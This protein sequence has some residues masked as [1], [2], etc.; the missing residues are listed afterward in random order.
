MQLQ[1]QYKEVKLC[2]DAGISFNH[3]CSVVE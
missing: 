1:K 3:L 2:S